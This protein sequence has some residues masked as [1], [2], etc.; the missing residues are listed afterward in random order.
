MNKPIDFIINTNNGTAS[1]PLY[2]KFNI[3]IPLNEWEFLC[4]KRW[5]SNTP[6]Q[7]EVEIEFGVCGARSASDNN[8]ANEIVNKTIEALHGFIEEDTIAECEKHLDSSKRIIGHMNE[9][10]DI[11]FSEEEN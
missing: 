5:F 1:F 7:H 8:E 3:T 4:Q 9:N 10:G 2:G 11:F 6:S